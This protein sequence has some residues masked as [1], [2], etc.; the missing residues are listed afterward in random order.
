MRYFLTHG[1]EVLA[2]VKSWSLERQGHDPLLTDQ[3]LVPGPAI[4]TNTLVLDR[5]IDHQVFNTNLA[6]IDMDN[7]DGQ[8]SCMMI[9]PFLLTYDSTTGEHV[10]IIRDQT[11]LSAQQLS[12]ARARV[13][14]YLHEQKQK[15]LATGYPTPS[16]TGYPGPSMDIIHS[17]EIAHFEDGYYR[18]TRQ[19][20]IDHGLGDVY[21]T[22]PGPG[23]YQLIPGLEYI[24]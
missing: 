17:D 13:L 5:V 19:Q 3:G 10:F 12:L 14:L 23:G 18:R 2:E 16:D 6:I 15:L 8:W 9:D 7:P 4:W 22:L 1:L 20:A 11:P 21:D 24:S